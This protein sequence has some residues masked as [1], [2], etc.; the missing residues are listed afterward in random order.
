ML[1]HLSIQCDDYAGEPGVLRRG[2]GAARRHA[3][4]GFRDVRR[5]RGRRQARL[6]DLGAYDRRRRTARC[7]V[8]FVAPDRAAV[9]AF[10]DAAVA[11]RRRSAARAEGLARVPP[12]LLRRVRARSRRQQRRGRVSSARSD[13]GRRAGR[14]RSRSAAPDVG[15]PAGEYRPQ[16]SAVM[17]GARPASCWSA[18]STA[19]SSA[20]SPSH[21]RSRRRHLGIR[22]RAS[23]AAGRASARR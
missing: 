8:A 3:H 14:D 22:R 23:P 19:R 2:A 10:F 20:A 6:L 11:T 13:A 9:R 17:R 18:R 16:L 4:H 1:D 5:I 12:E 7:H 15:G 21:D